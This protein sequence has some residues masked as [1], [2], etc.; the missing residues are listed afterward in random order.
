MGLDFV[1][2]SFF[3][4]SVE[5]LTVVQNNTCMLYTPQVDRRLLSLN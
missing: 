4:L 2:C 3:I 1:K 5:N